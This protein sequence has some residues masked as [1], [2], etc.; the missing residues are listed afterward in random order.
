MLTNAQLLTLKA[1]INADPV[2][3]LIPLG[4]DGSQT[5]ADAYNALAA[6]TFQVWDP[7]ASAN[8]I[9]D[10]IDWSKY[11]PVDAPDVT[12]IFTNRMLAVQTKQMNLQ[13]MLFGREIVDASRANIRAGI[14]DAVIGLPTGAAGATV[15]AGGAGG[16][17][18]LTTMTRPATRAEKLFASAPVA[19]GP[20]SAAVM[21]VI[22]DL[23]H[24]D[25][26]A[27][28]LAV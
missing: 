12:A 15:S 17:T 10:A 11:T 18:V 21:T 8:A 26:T 3:S 19:T 28:R 6:P 24:N 5:I 7:N 1:D 14:R 4:S 20:V 27:A 13:S 16:A 25:I 9:F 23:S 2:L 22:G